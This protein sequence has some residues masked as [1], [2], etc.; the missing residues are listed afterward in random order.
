MI[1]NIKKEKR[2]EFCD[3]GVRKFGFWG[4]LPSWL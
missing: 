3:Q 1:I 2:L 4:E